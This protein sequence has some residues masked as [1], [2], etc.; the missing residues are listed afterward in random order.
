MLI[1]DEAGYALAQEQ[2]I[3][4]GQNPNFFSFV[5]HGCVLPLSRLFPESSCDSHDRR[6]D[7]S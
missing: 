4:H 2:M 5:I 3:I 7:P 6:A 1:G